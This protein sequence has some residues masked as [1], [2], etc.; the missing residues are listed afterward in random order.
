M[1][2]PVHRVGRGGDDEGWHGG[3]GRQPGHGLSMMNVGT[4]GAQGKGGARGS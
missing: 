4:A 3:F 1:S 2:W